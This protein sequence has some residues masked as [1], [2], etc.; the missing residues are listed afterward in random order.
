M[1]WG[2]ASNGDLLRRIA[3]Y[4]SNGFRNR[5]HVVRAIIMH[6]DGIASDQS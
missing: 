2:I 1:R 6:R 3:A 5:E 4:N